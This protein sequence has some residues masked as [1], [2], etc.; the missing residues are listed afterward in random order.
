MSRVFITK[1]LMCN[2][3]ATLQSFKWKPLFPNRFKDDENNEWNLVRGLS[4]LVLVKALN[5]TYVNNQMARASTHFDGKGLEKG[6][7]WDITF[8]IIRNSVR[9]V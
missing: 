6:V 3:I 4:S 9:L 7:E 1:S 8:K 5:Q 2:V